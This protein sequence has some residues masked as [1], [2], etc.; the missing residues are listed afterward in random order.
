MASNKNILKI[1]QEDQQDRLKNQSEKT[2]LS[3]VKKRDYKRRQTVLKLLK[4]KMI[5]TP[6]D[7]FRAAMIFHHGV[8]RKH[9]VKAKKLAK[10][11][12]LLG[13]KRA[14]WLYAATIDRLLVLQGK[15]QQ[16]GTQYAPKNSP[17]GK[18]YYELLP[19][20]QNF[21]DSERIKF[22]IKPLKKI[23][24]ILKLKKDK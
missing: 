23:S 13:N 4:N 11:S 19:I 2:W 17:D 16:F 5:I 22:N 1:F 20:N 18:K 6:D 24:K 21:P 12:M 14:K 10:K 9:I 3:W 7:F 15:H 8:N